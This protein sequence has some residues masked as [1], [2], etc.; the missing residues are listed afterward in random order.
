M[1]EAFG[2]GIVS[3]LFNKTI[4]SSNRSE[5]ESDIDNLSSGYP[6]A[7]VDSENWVYILNISKELNTEWNWPERF[8]TQPQVLAY[9]RHVA[10]K[11]D[12]RKDIKFNARVKSAVWDEE[13]TY[14]NCHTEQG[15]VIS[16]RYFVS[17]TGPLTVPKELPFPG[18]KKFK[19]EWYQTARW[20]QT[21]VSFKGKRVAVS[22]LQT[23]TP[24]L[25]RSSY[26]DLSINTI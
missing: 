22:W 5:R 10:D 16:G 1:S 7:R 20:P 2:I 8:P 24:W 6:G 21:P 15:E 13:N 9:L 4:L 23:F 17:A 19:G 11:F 3:K 12:M 14:W 26:A 18:V 25:P